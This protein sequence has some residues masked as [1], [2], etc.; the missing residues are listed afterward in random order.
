MTGGRTTASGTADDR[1]SLPTT[2]AEARARVQDVLDAHPEALSRTVVNDILLVTSELVTNALR[3]GGGLTAFHVALEP[4]GLR[5][6]VTDRSADPPR[7]AAS[8]SSQDPAGRLGGFGW[9]LIQRLSRSVTITPAPPG[10]TIAAVLAYDAP[11][12]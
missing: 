2:A 12:L 3:H 11:A 7:T 4:Q 8:T 5:I 9:P 6:A 1:S 10:K